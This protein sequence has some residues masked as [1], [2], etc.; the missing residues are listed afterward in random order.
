M[1]RRP[2]VAHHDADAGVAN[3]DPSD[4]MLPVTFS[5]STPRESGDSSTGNK[6]RVRLRTDFVDTVY[7]PDIVCSFVLSCRARHS[8]EQR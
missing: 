5:V 8:S 1:S 7:L 2:I 3:L 6:M 4:L